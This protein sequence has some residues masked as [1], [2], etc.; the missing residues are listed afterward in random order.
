MLKKILHPS[1]VKKKKEKKET[2]I[3]SSVS[4]GAEDL[5]VFSETLGIRVLIGSTRG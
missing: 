1:A 5:N 4:S 3:L 2:T